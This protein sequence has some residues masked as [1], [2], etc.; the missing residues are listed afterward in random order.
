[1]E[2]IIFSLPFVRDTWG[3]YGKLLNLQTRNC[4]SEYIG[5]LEIR[6]KLP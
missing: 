6:E 5:I 3:I 1:M 2:E 4:T